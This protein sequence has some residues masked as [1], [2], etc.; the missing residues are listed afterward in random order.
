LAAG[1]HTRQATTAR[2]TFKYMA[3]QASTYFFI[4]RLSDPQA[5]FQVQ[6]APLGGGLRLDVFWDAISVWG[7]TTQPFDTFRPEVRSALDLMVAAYVFKTDRPIDYRLENWAEAKGVEGKEGV[8]GRFLVPN[9]PLPA[10]PPTRSRLNTPWKLAAKLN[11]ARLA[12]SVTQ[13]HVFALRDYQQALLEPSD[14]AFIYAWRAVE[15]TCRAVSGQPDVSAA[16]WTAMHN[17]LQTKGPQRIKV[18]D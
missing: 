17:A 11:R 8:V 12:G 13:N 18:D 15:D 10:L 14:N 16:T 3:N 6:D 9:Q 7:T 5:R 4:G 1:D 2:R